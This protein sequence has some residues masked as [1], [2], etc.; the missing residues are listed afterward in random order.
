MG[1]YFSVGND[2]I[3]LDSIKKFKLD[4]IKCIYRPL[5]LHTKTVENGKETTK[6]KYLTMQPVKDLD[7][8][9][10]LNTVNYLI[11]MENGALEEEKPAV[12]K[13]STDD[14]RVPEI[15]VVKVLF[16]SADKEYT[17]LEKYDCKNVKQEYNRIKMLINDDGLLF[18]TAY[19]FKSRC[20]LFKSLTS[21][22]LVI[23]AAVISTLFV[24]K[25]N[26]DVFTKKPKNVVAQS[27]EK[28]SNKE[29]DSETDY[30]FEEVKEKPNVQTETTSEVT[31]SYS[32]T[33]PSIPDNDYN[34]NT[35]S[36]A[37]VTA[38]PKSNENSS[39]N[40]TA[41]NGQ[42]VYITKTGTKYHIKSTCAGKNP[43]PK[44]YN[45]IKDTYE[46]CKRCCH[47]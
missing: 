24:L 30:E 34:D 28:F 44:N 3:L 12:I 35:T 41:Q 15:K 26:P 33:A 46:P 6:Y 42:T 1:K 20:A 47:Q 18:K 8:E 21:T 4:E 43:I 11:K 25:N 45:E 7:T 36:V 9:T 16:V 40:A 22:A 17:F 37:S 29:N 19:W 23:L 39:Q 32:P 5:Y 31:S 27:V 13:S 2:H 38:E 10:K 14:F